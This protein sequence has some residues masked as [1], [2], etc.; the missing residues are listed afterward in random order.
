MRSGPSGIS[1]FAGERARCPW[2]SLGLPRAVAVNGQ[3]EFPQFRAIII[4]VA[5]H[6]VEFLLLFLV[7]PTLF[8]YG[9]HQIPA[10]PMLWVLMTYC[11]FILL[12][13]PAFDRRSLWNTA[14][15][16][17]YAPSILGLF[18]VTALIG[19]TLVM[20]FG[21]PGLFLNFPRS[22]PRLWSLVMVLYPVLS[23]YP[24]GIIYRAFVFERY[25]DLFGSHWALVLASTF[26]FTWVHIVF[27]NRLALLLT[28]L[29]G[30]LFGMRFMQTGS[31]LVTS[32]EHA[33]YGCF[34]F[35]VGVGRSFHHASARGTS[36]DGSW[37]AR[38][39]S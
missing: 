19:I 5:M 36:A 28:L 8:A 24:Q 12:R 20:R 29:G 37:F 17:H 34:M 15:L 39:I 27:R 31:L 13:D 14:P 21:P 22:N 6:A 16:G 3:G 32:F 2:K 10:I 11:L 38:S 4:A 35:T 1:P 23:V 33:L 26:A 9:R 25:R 30:I 7:G 18:A